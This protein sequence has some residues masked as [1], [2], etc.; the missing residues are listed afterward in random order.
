MPRAP[1]ISRPNYG[2]CT[3]NTQINGIQVKIQ[4]STN[5][6]FEET[7]QMSVTTVNKNSFPI[8]LKVPGWC[9]NPVIKIN[10]EEVSID[11]NEM[12]FAF[13]ERTWNSGDKIDLSLIRLPPEPVG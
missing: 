9:D 8:H 11:I 7:I 4:S 6:P 12:G 2:P 13:I 10:N 3:L 1:N 5:Y